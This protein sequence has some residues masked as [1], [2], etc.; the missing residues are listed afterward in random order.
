MNI[1]PTWPVDYRRP[2][3]QQIYALDHI[4]LRGATASGVK[5]HVDEQLSDHAGVSAKITLAPKPKP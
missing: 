4:F 3:T 1:A 2:G 5:V